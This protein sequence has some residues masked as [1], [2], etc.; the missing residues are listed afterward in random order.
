[1]MMNEGFIPPQASHTRLSP[2]ISPSSDMMH[3]SKEL[4]SWDTT[5]KAALVNSYGASGSNTSMVV[6][7]HPKPATSAQY[8][9]GLE[10]IAFPF[11]IPGLDDNRISAYC[12]RLDEY[13]RARPSLRLADLS[14]NLSRQSNRNLAKQLVFSCRSMSELQATLSRAASS[15]EDNSQDVPAERPVILC[16]GGQVSTFVGLDRAVYDQVDVLRRYLDECDSVMT[17]MGLESIYPD[18]FSR[19][20]IQDTVKLQSMLFAIQY[21]CARSWMDSGLSGK[22]TAVVGH[23]FGELTALCV[24]G[25]LSIQDAVKLVAGRARLIRDQWG[26]DKGAMV[27]VEADEDVVHEVLQEARNASPN[28]EH[29]A[30]IACYNG[31]R[32]FTLAGSTA[33]IQGV[34]ETIRSKFT[35]L[36]H[37]QLNVTNSFHC[38]LTDGLVEPL[39]KLGEELS[40]NSP[41][42][43][44][45]HSTANPPTGARLSSNFVANHLRNPVYFNHAVQRLAKAYPDSVWLEA[46][47]NSTITTMASRA[48]RPTSSGVTPALHQHFQALNITGG[49]G[50]DGITET[51]QALWKEGLRV[52]F[53]MHHVLQMDRYTHHILPPHQ[54]ARTRHGLEIR[55]RGKPEN[56]C[57]S[58][59]RE[60]IVDFRR[61]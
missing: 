1:M 61:L 7:Q 19:S 58:R 29:P 17:S 24:S 49:R 13:I 33:A 31:P 50:V 28:E 60:G 10:G 15:V 21:S 43:H 36:R 46:G 11:W 37:K 55:S 45:E 16:F 18:I 39:T 34:I 2:R 57:R 5:R 52:S 14:F 44:I 22:I 23:S 30:S 8:A 12:A 51:T 27:A 32:S 54:F 3:I 9:A 48:L 4:R 25:I 56:Q 6:L 47:S 53:W 41:T 59:E 40:F 38:S 35:T 20:P 26:S 42:I